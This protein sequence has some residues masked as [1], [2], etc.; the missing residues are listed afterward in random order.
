MYWVVVALQGPAQDA[1]LESAP[2]DFT[3]EQLK[4]KLEGTPCLLWH[5]EDDSDVPVSVAHYLAGVLPAADVR[6]VPGESHSMIRRKWGEFLSALV[7]SVETAAPVPIEK[8]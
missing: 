5:G 8:K 7:T 1:L 2:W 6:I 4:E 3:L